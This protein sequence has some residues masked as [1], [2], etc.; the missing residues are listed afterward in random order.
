VREE[1][2]NKR[3]FSPKSIIAIKNNS[4]EKILKE[5]KNENNLM[6]EEEGI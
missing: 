4:Y 6:K 3:I 5:L 1:D 2:K